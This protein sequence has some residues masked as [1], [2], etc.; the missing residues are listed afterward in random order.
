M[1]TSYSEFKLSDLYYKKINQ[2]GYLV[3]IDDAFLSST[4]SLRKNM[5]HAEYVLWRYLRENQINNTRFF[6]QFPINGY[7]VDFYSRKYKLA[8]E[9][10][11]GIH[12]D[13]FVKIQDI[14]RQ[15]ILEH[16]GVRFLRFKN[17]EVLN[18]I[19]LVIETIKRNLS[20]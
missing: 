16:Y 6:R 20:N 5:T 7:V 17:K 2:Q 4:R 10:D 8:I 19:N 14:A 15:K 13:Y 3:P 11:G 1:S 9:I 12:D 18:S